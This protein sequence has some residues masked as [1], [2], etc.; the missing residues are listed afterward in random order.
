VLAD[1]DPPGP[2]TPILI[3]RRR[4]SCAS[5]RVLIQPGGSDSIS[6][7]R[8]VRSVAHHRALDSFVMF[9][10]ATMHVTPIS[11]ILVII[12]T[13]GVARVQVQ[14]YC[15]AS[16]GILSV[17]H[18]EHN[19]PSTGI[20]SESH[21]PL[22]RHETAGPPHAPCRSLLSLTIPKLPSDRL[23]PNIIASPSTFTTVNPRP[24]A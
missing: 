17:L 13:C 14:E 19:I 5:V 15:N 8:Q 12:M 21:P 18:K 10:Q 11:R 9:T 6:N 20:Y 16:P 24:W 22:S 7:P 2:H 23:T 3:P 1:S 4:H